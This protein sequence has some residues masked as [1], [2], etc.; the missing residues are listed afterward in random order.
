M[1]TLVCVMRDIVIEEIY[2]RVTEDKYF[3][4]IADETQDSSKMEST[5]VLKRYIEGL[6]ES[7]SITSQ[8]SYTAKQ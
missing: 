6:E 3:S 8:K 4:I 5:V 7:W 2:K 1:F